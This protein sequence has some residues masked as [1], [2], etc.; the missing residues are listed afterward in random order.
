MIEDDDEQMT[1]ELKEAPKFDIT[2][3]EED[4][5]GI[6]EEVEEEEYVTCCSCTCTWQDIL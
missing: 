5:D 3:T 1:E 4:L 2:L 6:I